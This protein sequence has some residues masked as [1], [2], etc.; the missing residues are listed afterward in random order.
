MQ[1]LEVSVAELKILQIFTKK[2]KKKKEFGDITV[3]FSHKKSY[4]IIFLN[5]QIRNG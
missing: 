4:F 3:D 2:Q 1:F 5:M